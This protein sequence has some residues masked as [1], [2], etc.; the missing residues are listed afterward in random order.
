[1]H[2]LD[3]TGLRLVADVGGTNTRLALSRDG[4]IV[5]GTVRNYANDAWDSFYLVV[6]AFLDSQNSH[7]DEMVIAVAGPVRNGQARLTNRSW[8]IETSQINAEFDCN[9]IHLL[10]DLNALAY[11]TPALKSQQLR[12]V[13]AGVL[14][15][16]S[17]AQ[18]LVVG[19]GTGFN[20]GPVLEKA[21]SM[22]CPA[23]EAGHATL[24][25]SVSRE[26][27]RA[28]IDLDHFETVEM[29]FSGR[30]FTLFC[31]QMTG[32]ASLEGRAV[33]SAYERGTTESISAAVE[34][35]AKLFGRLLG[36]LSMSYMPTSGIFLA[37][38]VAR[39]IM[40]V[41][42][43]ACLRE[44]SRPGQIFGNF[45]PPVW[46]IEDDAAA[47]LGCLGYEFD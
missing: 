11:A 32:D 6:T 28:G 10:N 36:D 15:E 12:L 24:P 39:A 35:Y 31:K 21:G 2:N 30:G 8:L 26:L 41:A 29:L 43:E 40:R 17:A 20:V 3:V 16:T 37:G 9:K 42:Q 47:L 4:A 7:P 5:S 23:V 25:L 14:T 38:S 1:M 18:S 13:R 34:T 46:V 22:F 45:T 27:T 44:M 33:I 19:V